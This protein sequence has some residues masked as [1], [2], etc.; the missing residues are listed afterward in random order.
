MVRIWRI[1]SNIND[2]DQ[3]GHKETINLEELVG[4]EE[5][6]E[7]DLDILDMAIYIKDKYN[8]SKNAYHE[9]AQIF[10][11]MPRYYK[12]KERIQELNKK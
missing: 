8:I 11:N 10:K 12:I 7:E 5:A 4:A 9:M 2:N 6:D 1:H 3:T